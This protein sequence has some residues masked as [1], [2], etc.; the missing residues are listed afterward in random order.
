[1]E[2]YCIECKK[3]INAELKT[4]KEIYPHRPD[5]KNKYIYQCPHCK[6]YV[7]THPNTII[8]L[9]CIPNFQ[10]K[11]ARKRVHAVLDPLWKSKRYSRKEIYKIISKTLGYEYHT[12]NTKS[13]EE[14]NRVIEIIKENFEV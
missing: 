3:Q 8:P 7:G 14:C 1:M 11:Q 9:G 13:I 4:G 2:I 10:I 12:G 6:N 5:L